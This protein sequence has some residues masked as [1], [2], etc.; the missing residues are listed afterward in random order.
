MSVLQDL[1]AALAQGTK[2][3]WSVSGFGR[4]HAR[5]YEVC[6]DDRMDRDDA[7]L[8]CLLVNAAPGM[9]E[10]VGLLREVKGFLAA[11]DALGHSPATTAPD[12]R[13]CVMERRI[14]AAIA[15]LGETKESNAREGG[16]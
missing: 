16:R 4:I 5:D 9:L 11:H 12:C 13:I 15:A 8:I 1:R 6:I 3:P 7:A 14:D 10:C 2:G